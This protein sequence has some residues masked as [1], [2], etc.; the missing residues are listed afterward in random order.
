MVTL[1][2]RSRQWIVDEH[3]RIIMGEGRME[4]LKN[5]EK[6]GSINKTSK[7][8]KM[9]YKGAWSKIKATEKYLNARIVNT[10]RKKGAWL[11]DEGKILLEKY[12]LLKERCIE[13]DNKIFDH[14]FDQE[15]S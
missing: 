13:E 7:I 1:R 6:T 2:L 8:M 4:I 12:R 3:D 9:S 11:T 14:I 10:D 5:I 15:V